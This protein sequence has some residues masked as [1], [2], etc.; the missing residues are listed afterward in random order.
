MTTALPAIKAK[1]GSHEYYI[2][3]MRAKELAERLVIPK[4]LEEWE[5]MSLED[6]F[7]RDVNYNRVRKQI[8][9]Y[10][11][12]DKDRFFGAF[13][14]DIYNPEGVHFEPIEEIVKKLPTL[15][16][17]AASVFGFLYLRGDE[18]LVPLDGQHRLAAIRFAISGRD[19]KGKDIEGLQPNF[20]VATD[21]CTVILIKHDPVKA[22]K[23]F[24]KVNRYAKPTTK[25]ENLIT[26][27][28]DIIAIITR[29]EI[30][31][32]VLQARL[33]NY[34]SNTLS[35]NA[36][37][38]T[39]LSTLYE[40]TKLILENR[41]NK[42]S[43]T[44]LPSDADQNLYR[45]EAREFWQ[46]IIDNVK[47]F[48]M[49]LHDPSEAGDV[50]RREVRGTYTLGKPIAQLS[51]FDAVLRLNAPRD[52]GKKLS[53]EEITRRINT[54]NWQTDNPLWQRVLMNGNKVIVGRQAAK[55]A[56][57]FIAYYLGAPLLEKELQVLE[58]QYKEL[59]SSDVDFPP[60]AFEPE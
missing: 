51:L 60:R 14:V 21:M 32:K 35:E 6:R 56:A 43:T 29:Q 53:L 10:L 39:T 1:F 49:A 26:A 58:E 55:F 42:I 37:E 34:K 20:E 45:A 15:Y 52:D 33:V 40:V 57:R 30:T 25:A 19:Q 41:F 13:I 3:T 16:Q 11:A 17:H 27:D 12:N 7:Q 38:F 48:E 9:P 50:K 28:D 54:V 36:P 47:I 46:H 44:E 24:N 22:R 4:D 2:V 59:F 23:I 8:A 18:V 5:D 31:D